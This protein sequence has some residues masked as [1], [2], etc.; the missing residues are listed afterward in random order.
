MLPRSWTQYCPESSCVIR[1]CRADT[2]TLSTTMS[3]VS[4]RPAMIDL[5]LTPNERDEV[6]EETEHNHGYTDS[7]E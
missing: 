1:Q 5:T 7:E 4:A 6:Q 2:Y 3:H